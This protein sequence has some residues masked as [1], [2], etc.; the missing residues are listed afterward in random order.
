MTNKQRITA[1]QIIKEYQDLFY[2]NRKKTIKF[3]L[4]MR[5]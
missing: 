1:N 2:E 5:L 4:N 3:S